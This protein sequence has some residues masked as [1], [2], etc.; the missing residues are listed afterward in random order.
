MQATGVEISSYPIAGSDMVEKINYDEKKQRIYINAEQ[1]FAQVPS[2]IWNFYIGG[3]QV[4][5][6]WLKERKDRKL[7]NDETT[8]KILSLI[9]LKP[10]KLCK[11][12]I[13]S[14]K[15]AAV[16]PLVC[17]DQY[18]YFRQIVVGYQ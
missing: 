18:R 8:I 16:F 10:L 12:S 15:T 11:T 6:K 2:A 13:I 4:C 9:S 1:Y 14:L 7:T 17:N 3:Y 5:Q